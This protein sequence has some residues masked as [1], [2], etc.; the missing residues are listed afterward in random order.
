MYP[1]PHSGMVRA[2]SHLP[3]TVRIPA[4]SSGPLSTGPAQ[5][6]P[7]DARTRTPSQRQTPTTPPEPDDDHHTDHVPESDSDHDD[8]T[9]LRKPEDSRPWYMPRITAKDLHQAP[10]EDQPDSNPI[11]PNRN[12]SFDDTPPAPSI[13]NE[14]DG[15]SSIPGDNRPPETAP[16]DPAYPGSSS[17]RK[18]PAPGVPAMQQAGIG[19]TAPS[20][21]Q[22]LQ[23]SQRSIAALQQQV[24]GSNPPANGSKPTAQSQAVSPYQGPAPDKM[25]EGRATSSKNASAV[26]EDSALRPLRPGRST[27]PGPQYSIELDKTAHQMRDLLLARRAVYDKLKNGNMPLSTDELTRLMEVDYQRGLRANSDS[28]G[29]TF[30]KLRDDA[31]NRYFYHIE[32]N[33]TNHPGHE[34]FRGSG[35]ALVE[36]PEAQFDNPHIKRMAR[37][38]SDPYFGWEINYN[39]V[40]QWLRISGYNKLEAGHFLAGW[41]GASPTK[42]KSLNLDRQTWFWVGYDYANARQKGWNPA[43]HIPAAQPVNYGWMTPPPA[44]YPSRA[45]ERFRTH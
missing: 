40:G 17:L 31:D 42:W 23:E 45:P 2:F 33:K 15:Q 9:T 28:D 39:V 20:P 1:E 3:Q 26:G 27:D 29:M 14:A 7:S 13:L 25:D 5:P 36:S 21:Q 44:F 19:P 4:D 34:G 8:E 38:H 30:K 24:R 12:T 18:R 32:P 10:D 11:R 37:G 22:R 43:G 6:R 16:Q 41:L 35:F